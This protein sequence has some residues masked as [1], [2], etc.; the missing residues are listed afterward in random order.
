MARSLV[1]GLAGLAL[2]PSLLF[3]ATGGEVSRVTVFQDR[4]SVTRTRALHVERGP[5]SVAFEGVTPLL[6]LESLKARLGPGSPVT[7]LGIRHRERNRLLSSNPE[8]QELRKR[9]EKLENARS[10]VLAKVSSLVKQDRSLGDL[11]S[12]YRDSF[13]FNLHKKGW[14]KGEL[15]SFL[16][17]LQGHS[18]KM[19]Q[20]WHGLF[21]QHE[22]LQKEIEFVD[23][24]LRERTVA[25]D[26]RTRT[27]WVDLTADSP[28]NITVEI[29]Y[30]VPNAGWAP[31]YDLWV[32]SAKGEAVLDQKAF[33]WQRTGEDWKNVSLVLSNA[34][35]ELHTN[36]PSISPY[37]LSFRV[38]NEVKTG[39][40]SSSQDTGPLTVGSGEGAGDPEPAK[41]EKGLGRVFEVKGK[42]T[43]R[44]G[45]A[46]T[47]VPIASRRTSFRESLELIAGVYPRVFRRAELTNP[48]PWDLAS[49]TLAIY[50]DKEFVQQTHLKEVARGN[51]FGANIGVEHDLVVNRSQ[52]DEV[53]EP[54]LVDR[55]RHFK[56]THETWIENF[57]SRS[58][59][60][61]VLER[62]PVSELKDVV[63]SMKESSP[64]FEPEGS[65]EGWYKWNLDVAP[66][67]TASLKLKI[68]VAVPKDFQFSW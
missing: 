22:V 55:K 3:A 26:R 61:R 56:R 1:E 21:T 38:A 8:T 10:E 53:G 54:G 48:F 28:A 32:E 52:K 31:A 6:D 67:K 43:V 20:T 44:D 50:H 40:G 23:S 42:Q 18:E 11:A 4:A 65:V 60:I 16:H 63:V 58:K 7:I 51:R 62:V 13:T 30:L 39:V 59:K 19:N 57:S 37:T 35:T 12:H 66:R 27:V 17:F 68:D 34:R 29:Q 2:L 14:K 33:V 5:N 45:L 49:G 24:K 41:A 25:S 47:Q 15:R 64:G 46:R 36:P 9:R